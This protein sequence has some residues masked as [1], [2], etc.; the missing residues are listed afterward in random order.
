LPVHQFGG[1]G[2]GVGGADGGVEA[3]VGGAQ[4]VAERAQCENAVVTFQVL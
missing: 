1:L 2:H 3:G 4:R